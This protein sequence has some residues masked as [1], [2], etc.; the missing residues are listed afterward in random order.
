MPVLKRL[1]LL[2]LLSLGAEHGWSSDHPSVA[3][4]LLQQSRN[5]QM[6]ALGE[7]HRSGGEHS[8]IK[9][10][11]LNPH[12][13]DVFPIIVVEFGNALYQ[14]LA[15]RYV[16]G[17]EVPEQ[18]LK[19]VWRD[20]T[21]PMAWDSPLYADFF[22]AVRELNKTL[23]RG[24]KIRVL[25][26]DPPINWSQV[27]SVEKFKPYMDRDAFYANVM[28]RNCGDQ[29][30]LLICG[31]NHFYWKDP[32]SHLRP[33]SQHKNALEYYLQQKGNRT[34]VRSVLPVFSEDKIFSA[35]GAPSLL[36]AHDP[37]LDKLRFGQ[38]DHSPVSILK[39][40]DGKMQVV[41]VQPDDTLS[42]SEVIDWVLYLGATD[43]II[44]PAAS[45]YQDTAYIKELYRRTKIV[46]D[47]FGF[48]M[49]S[50]VEQ[51]DPNAAT[52]N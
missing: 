5:L 37:P 31:T 21:V 24:K 16:S 29:R 20:T 44:S 9:D 32:L 34:K 3:E 4:A 28:S 42:L 22:R 14:D 47:A 15:D 2:A 13:A 38:V 30:C 51:V 12:F 26:G 33:P 19:Q 49:T 23:V 18:Q 48:D 7:R 39:K 45:V 46:G 6:L 25:L 27:D 41:E 52:K 50:D 35:R 40:V 11:L 17:Q 10:L 43:P 36:T 8:F 1:M